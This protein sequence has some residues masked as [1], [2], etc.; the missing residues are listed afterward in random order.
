MGLFDALFGPSLKERMMPYFQDHSRPLH[1]RI[2]R[3]V[4]EVNPTLELG[5]IGDFHR[6]GS[7]LTTTTGASN[8]GYCLFAACATRADFNAV[9]FA[10]QKEPDASWQ[11]I[12]NSDKLDHANKPSAQ[13]GFGKYSNALTGVQIWMCLHD[14]GTPM[15]SIV[16]GPEWER[17]I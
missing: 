16:D 3:C 14:D 12:I 15:M 11:V 6:A 2:S 8:E 13:L 4:R 9:A 17:V 7:E 10:I 5:D 1:E